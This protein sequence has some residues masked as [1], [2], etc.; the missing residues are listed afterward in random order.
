MK[1]VFKSAALLTIGLV[2]ANGFTSCA[3]HDNKGDEETV[4]I[5]NVVLE[6]S[7]D[8]VI[9]TN[10]NAQVTVGSETQTGTE[11]TFSN[12]NAKG[13]IT[14]KAD[15]RQDKEVAYD[16]GTDNAL[17]LDITLDAL[18]LTVDQDKAE[19]G[20]VVVTNSEENV[21][22][23]N[24]DISIDFN[25]ATNT[26]DAVSDQPYS[27]NVIIPEADEDE[28]T[29][30]EIEEE[31][32][33]NAEEQGEE[34]AEVELEHAPLALDCQPSGAHF[35]TPITLNFELEQSEGLELAVVHDETGEEAVVSRD[36]DNVSVQVDHFSIWTII[37]K[38]IVTDIE[39]TVETQTIQA[40][41]ETGVIKY[42]VK[43]G[44][45]RGKNIK[46]K[47]IIDQFLLKV[48]NS[49]VKN[50]SKRVTFK[51]V[52]D[53]TATLQ[54]SQV[55]KT[56][57]FKCGNNTFTAKVYGKATTSLTLEVPVSESE[58]V[59]THS[60]GAVTSNAVEV[61]R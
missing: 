27:I 56:Y 45:E 7:R 21:E 43:S 32:A 39:E 34:N 53:A 55:V 57:T 60:G 10:V 3:I 58:N 14:L 16:F 28:P 26:N 49:K 24:V 48:F 8:L 11:L 42:T 37:L 54:V 33:Q 1:K 47:S 44:Y 19:S 29:I 5:E 50:V 4:V 9:T 46:A 31:Y 61:V 40:S 6:V 17:A 23:T 38:A 30:E 12:V 2:V 36:G 18:P 41:G 15:G 51:P 52:N 59:P 25:G 13:T 22:D 35:D 20:E